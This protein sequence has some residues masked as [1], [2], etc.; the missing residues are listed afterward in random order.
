MGIRPYGR[1]N[2]PDDVDNDLFDSDDET[3]D[4]RDVLRDR[5]AEL[6]AAQE[7]DL[8]M[9]HPNVLTA[10]FDKIDTSYGNG[11]WEWI[12]G[13]RH[14]DASP[15]FRPK[16]G[17]TITVARFLLEA[18]Y[19][20]KLLRSEYPV[21]TCQTLICAHPDHYTTTIK[22]KSARAIQKKTRI[23]ERL[24][25]QDSVLFGL[26]TG[27]SDPMR[28]IGLM[29][30]AYKYRPDET[31]YEYA[32]RTKT[33]G[34]R[35]AA[36]IVLEYQ[37]GVSEV[38]LATRWCRPVSFITWVLGGV[39]AREERMAIYEQKVAEG[40]GIAELE[41]EVEKEL[42]WDTDPDQRRSYDMQD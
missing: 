8:V 3:P 30:N 28:E 21:R 40:V 10:F 12:P 5:N 34:A 39:K 20:R 36:E 27:I 15:T 35:E 25:N 22:Q 4:E 18:L 41:D 16:N 2:Q 7:Y 14:R 13:R 19:G 33:I 29:L 23:M 42:V 17:K 11:C 31:P 26:K 1:N 32:M 38:D 24:K 9:S 37:D 6:L